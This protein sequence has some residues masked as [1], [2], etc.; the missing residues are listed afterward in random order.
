MGK[1]G[2]FSDFKRGSEDNIFR[3]IENTL[4]QERFKIEQDGTLGYRVDIKGVGPKK[5]GGHLSVNNLGDTR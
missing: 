5:V 1:I 2:E 3:N 4:L